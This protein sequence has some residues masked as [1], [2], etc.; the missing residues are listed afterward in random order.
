MNKTGLAIVE[1]S[2]EL[3]YNINRIKNKMY[4][5]DDI[6]LFLR[7]FTDYLHMLE[8][9][10]NVQPSNYLSFIVLDKMF[11]LIFIITS[12]VMFRKKYFKLKLFFIKNIFTFQLLFHL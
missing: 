7:I 12:K 4:Q 3:K 5:K 9:P 10:V 11:V 8:L 6:F 2:S 1:K